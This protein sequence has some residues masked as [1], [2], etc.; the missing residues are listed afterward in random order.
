[1]SPSA[2]LNAAPRFNRSA[3]YDALNQ[4]GDQMELELQQLRTDAVHTESLR[5]YDAARIN[6]IRELRRQ[7][8]K[9]DAELRELRLAEQAA[10]PAWQR[11]WAQHP[12]SR[13]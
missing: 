9:L 1:M 4:S 2:Y 10:D 5:S 13:Q 8:S 3:E 12:E 7:L 6:R 11:F